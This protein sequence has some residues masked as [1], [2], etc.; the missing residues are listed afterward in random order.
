MS[1]LACIKCRVFL[2]PKRNG[3]VVEEGRPLTN[4]K[5]GPWGPY[6]LWSADLAECPV[7]GFQLAVGFPRTP[8]AEH[9]QQDYELTRARRKPLV[10]IDSCTGYKP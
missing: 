5:D 9:F 8:L 6:K 10:R 3:I 1:G 4:D 7:C 2:V